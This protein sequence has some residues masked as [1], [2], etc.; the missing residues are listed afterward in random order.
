MTE[1]CKVCGKE[2]YGSYIVNGKCGYCIKEAR[3][4]K[5]QDAGK[6][7]FGQAN[8]ICKH[9]GKEKYGKYIG[10]GHCGYCQKEKKLKARL[11]AGKLPIGSGRSLTCPKCGK[12]KEKQNNSMCRACKTE[13]SKEWYRKKFKSSE[14]IQEKREIRRLKYAATDFRKKQLLAQNI[15]KR[16]IDNGWLFRKPCEICGK[17]ENIDAHHDDY[18]KPLEVKWLC[19]LCH[20][21]HHAEKEL[22]KT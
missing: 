4:K 20:R 11:E 21:E 7:P 17:T 3:L 6:L 16:C 2:K 22:T 14:A 1:R 5:R 8:F 9:C 13:S 10:T 15:V 12:F 19:R 18:S